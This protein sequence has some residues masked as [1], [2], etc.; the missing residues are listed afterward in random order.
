LCASISYARQTMK[1]E[2]LKSKRKTLSFL[3]SDQ[4]RLRASRQR[5]KLWK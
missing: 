3:D 2:I 4:D 1:A 5:T